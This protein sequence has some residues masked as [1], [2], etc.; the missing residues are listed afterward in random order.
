MLYLRPIRGMDKDNEIL[1]FAMLISL[2]RNDAAAQLRQ[3]LF[4]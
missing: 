1:W 3:I 4:W 2:Q